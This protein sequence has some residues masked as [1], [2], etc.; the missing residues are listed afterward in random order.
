MVS[1]LDKIT[2]PIVSTMTP[3][4]ANVILDGMGGTQHTND[5][6]T[7]AS[8]ITLKDPI[9]NAIANIVKYAAKKTNAIAGDGTTTSVL[10]TS[11]IIKEGMKLID[12]GWNNMKLKRTIEEAGE[13]VLS[14]ID[15]VVKKID[16]DDKL[17]YIASVASNNDDDIA[18]NVT[19]T[20]K[21]SGVDG[22]VVIERGN[23]EATELKKEEGFIIEQG[24][25]SPL[26]ANMNGKF[27]A[28]YKDVKII[29]TDR[30]IYSSDEALCFLRPLAEKGIKDVVIVAQDFIGPSPNIF[31]TN[32]TQQKMNILLIKDNE[33]SDKSITS[34][35]DLASYI[36]CN[37]ISL[38]HGKKPEDIT[39]DDYGTLDRI[40]SSHDRTVFYAKENPSRTLR[41]TALR[42][43]IDSEK[44]ED[45]KNRL[46]KRLARMTTGS[47]TIYVGGKTEPEITERVY[48]YEDAIN[49]TRNAYKDGYIVG[50]GIT[51]HNAIKTSYSSILGKY[52][53]DVAMM[54]ENICLSPLKQ[55]AMN[56]DIHYQTLLEKVEKGEGYNAAKEEYENIEE[57]GIIEPVTVLKMALKNSI[58]AA[59]I[60]LGSKYIIVEE[61]NEEIKKNV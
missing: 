38:K 48:R 36:G 22:L 18:K 32:H 34:L 54:M 2:E 33:C 4:G 42:D 50:G 23:K 24:M 14:E 44:D 6:I 52:G 49:A 53:V 9:E 31:I 20:I 25:F 61:E 26:L 40:M 55:I 58:S 46:E 60:I 45:K 1:G 56:C 43:E 27:L 39:I 10:L 7:I 15:K 17:T 12:N 51:L 28:S 11:A 37:I 41:V 47:V 59:G 3:K 30:R 16:S 13:M 35:E 21:T 19:D 8:H 29:L 57:A 5:G